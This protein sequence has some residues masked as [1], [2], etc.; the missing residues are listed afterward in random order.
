M[1]DRLE[2]LIESN[3]KAILAST[4]QGVELNNKIVRVACLR[5]SH[6]YR[7]QQQNRSN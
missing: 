7:T 4:N 3:A 6:Q 2:Q 5:Q 1:S